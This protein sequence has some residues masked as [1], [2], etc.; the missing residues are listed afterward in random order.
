[1][2]EQL[3]KFNVLYSPSAKTTS[4]CYLD[5]LPLINSG[6][7]EL[8]DHHPRLIEQLASLE[9]RTGFGSGRDAIDHPKG[10]AFHD[11]VANCVG[12]LASLAVGTGAYDSTYSGFSLP[13]DGLGGNVDP[14][15][16]RAQRA[17]A[18]LNET[19]ARISQ[20]PQPPH[21]LM[22]LIRRCTPKERLP[23]GEPI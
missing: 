15:I 17:Q 21:D 9:R 1:V 6:R 7:I 5:L 12:G 8:P 4:D 20:S 23:N 22:D 18:R 19:I 2:I 11:D 10:A 3:G 14:G 13:G 16:A